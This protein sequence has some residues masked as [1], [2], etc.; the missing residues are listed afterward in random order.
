MK[1]KNNQL[2]FAHPVAIGVFVVTL[3]VIG[4][5]GYRVIN[6]NDKK[7]LNST[8][9]HVQAEDKL[10]LD[11]SEVLDVSKVKELA[12]GS[13]TASVSNL[14]LENE[15]GQLVYKVKLSDGSMVVLDA[16]TGAKVTGATHAN[17]VEDEQGTLPA[18]FTVLVSFSKAREIA[19][20]KFP[21][22]TINKIEL[23]VEAGKVVI[24]VRF[25]DKARVDVDATSGAVVRIKDSKDAKPT[26]SSPANTTTPTNS[27]VNSS[28]SSSTSGG[29]SRSGNSGSGTSS[30]SSDS[31]SS[32]SGSGSSSTNSGSSSNNG[33][34]NSGNDSS[35]TDDDNDSHDDSNDDSHGSN[36]G[37]GSRH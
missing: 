26:Q 25:A 15:H 34:S 8:E 18:D 23:D 33:S 27:S 35:G 17:E 30:P 12:I 5:A 36:S 21:N 16:K 13:S 29:S 9:Q 1:L 10:P 22:G 14:E 31:G 7:Q 20:A 19:Q 11:L 4:F 3:V 37:S 24:S 28:A 2:G 6:N 32:N